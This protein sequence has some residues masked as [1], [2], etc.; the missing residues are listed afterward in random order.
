MKNHTL[1]DVLEKWIKA[2][3][4]SRELPLPVKYKSV[5]LIFKK[6]EF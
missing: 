3:S 4:L 1:H 6:F 2:W 5:E